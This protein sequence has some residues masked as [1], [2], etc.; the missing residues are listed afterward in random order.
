MN[1]FWTSM[2]VLDLIAPAIMIIIG[3]AIKKSSRKMKSKFAYRSKMAKKNRNT[4]KY[5]QNFCGNFLI[6]M[7]AIFMIVA[8]FI[9]LII[10]ERENTAIGIVGKTIC[11]LQSVSIL[12][13]F[14]STELA[15]RIKFDS[16][17]NG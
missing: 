2:L 15:L 5:A 11:L 9:M 16:N 8:V 14:G 1:K 3:R 17:G 12:I 4:W 13:P 7:G 6:N 10:C